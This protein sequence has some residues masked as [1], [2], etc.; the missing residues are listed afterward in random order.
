MSVSIFS[1]MDILLL[2]NFSIHLSGTITSTL[3]LQ[4]N[5][6]CTSYNGTL[7]ICDGC[8]ISTSA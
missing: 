1:N 7:Q 5:R 2:I 8:Y 4:S 3:I 6:D